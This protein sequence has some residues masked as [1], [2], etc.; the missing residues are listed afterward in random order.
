MGKPVVATDGGGEAELIENGENGQLIDS[1]DS[2]QLTDT[3]YEL[4][5]S[6]DRMSDI[7]KA[8]RSHAKSNF[9]RI[10]NMDHFES[11]IL[12]L[13]VDPRPVVALSPAIPMHDLP[14][15]YF[16]RSCAFQRAR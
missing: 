8:A 13:V 2:K 3:L 12:I 14:N 16:K 10:T 6:P 1:G 5:C 11:L 15:Q 7:G 9:D 4:I